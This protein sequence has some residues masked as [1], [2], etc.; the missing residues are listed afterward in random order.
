M[1]KKGLDALFVHYGIRQGD[2]QVIEA[3]CIEFDVDAEWLKEYILKP[4]HEAKIKNDELDTKTL[5]KLIEK[6]LSKM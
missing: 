1:S 5:T 2:M 6:G 3:L 4:Y